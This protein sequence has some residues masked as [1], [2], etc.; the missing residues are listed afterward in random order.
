MREPVSQRYMARAVLTARGTAHLAEL[1]EAEV[2]AA[3]MSRTE[4]DGEVLRL[5][6]SPYPLPDARSTS[7]TACRG[8]Q[9]CS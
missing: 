8:R 1:R 6:R 9:A 3:T 7:I 2:T 4:R 5:A